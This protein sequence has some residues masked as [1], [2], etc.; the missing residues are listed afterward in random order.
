MPLP[1]TEQLL[2][3]LGFV[4]HCGDEELKLAHYWTYSPDYSF[5]QHDDGR[6]TFSYRGKKIFHVTDFMDVVKHIAAIAHQAGIQEVLGIPEL[7][8]TLKD[9]I[10]DLMPDSYIN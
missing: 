6:W 3:D 1:I 7:E 4:Q 5:N 10:I 8:K 9:L 2:K